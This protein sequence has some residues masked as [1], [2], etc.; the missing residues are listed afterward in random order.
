[1]V[2]SLWAMHNKVDDANS[3]CIV[4]CSFASVSTSTLLVA[5]SYVKKNMST[6]QTAAVK[7]PY[8]N[9]DFTVLDEGTT[10]SE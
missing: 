1:M 2:L 10:K 5:S 4:L 9:N 6:L 8:Q 3:V 7:V